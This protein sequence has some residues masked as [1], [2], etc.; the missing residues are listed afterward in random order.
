MVDE[1]IRIVDGEHL[2]GRILGT[3]M[4]RNSGMHWLQ[5]Y[6]GCGGLRST[7]PCVTVASMQVCQLRP[8]HRLMSNRSNRS[9]SGI[10]GIMKLA[11]LLSQVAL[12]S[13]RRI[14][15]MGGRGGL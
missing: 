11:S 5:S 10:Y 12:Q 9:I 7:Q 6:S 14:R 15:E 4:V 3:T 1:S 2:D 8:H 13:S